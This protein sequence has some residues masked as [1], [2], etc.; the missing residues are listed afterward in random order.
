[1]RAQR[2]HAVEAAFAQPLTEELLASAGVAPGMRVLVLGSALADLTLLVA[3]RVGHCGEVVAAHADR[4]VIADARRR[5]SYE[6][7]DRIDFRTESL[8]QINEGR[9]FDA[10][11]GRF[12]LMHE[13]D[14]VRA[15][16]LAAGTAR[17]DGRI[18]F[19]EWHYDSIL[20]AETSDWPNVPLYRRFAKWSIEGLRRRNAHVNMGLQLVNAFVEAG[21]PLPMVRADMRVVHGAGALGYAFFEAELRDLLPTLEACGIIGAQDVDVDTFAQRLESET[22]AAGGHVFLPLLVGAWSRVPSVGV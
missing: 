6:G 5:A 19:Q 20:W 1:M 3:E 15:M 9:T 18:V 2:L 14:P 13:A 8:E 17:E 11:I 22:I 21:L 7:F 4:R 10:V 12:F 16:R